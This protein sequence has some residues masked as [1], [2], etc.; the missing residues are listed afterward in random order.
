MLPPLTIKTVFLSNLQLIHYKRFH[1][2][3]GEE[4]VHKVVVVG[5][6]VEYKRSLEMVL[7]TTFHIFAV[8][9]IRK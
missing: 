9:D 5:H 7:V 8:R 2:G 6:C 1:K 4:G 3:V